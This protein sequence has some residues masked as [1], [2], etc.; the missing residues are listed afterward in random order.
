MAVSMAY[1]KLMEE[2]GAAADAAWVEDGEFIAGKVGL[3]AVHQR[4]ASMAHPELPVFMYNLGLMP[5]LGN[6]ISLNLWGSPDPVA[7]CVLNVNHSQ[8][9]KSRLTGMQRSSVAR[10][11]SFV[12]QLCRQSGRSKA[13]WQPA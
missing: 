12:G 10:S 3:S 7:L 9:R 8:T 6:G 4:S 5:A 13:K 11:I 2:V 1:C